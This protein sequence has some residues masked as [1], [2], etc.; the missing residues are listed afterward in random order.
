ML[1]FYPVSF[2]LA[3]SSKL[4][5]NF[6]LFI[7]FF[8]IG[9]IIMRSAG[10]IINDIWDKDIDSKVDRTKTRPIAS[11]EINLTKAII[12]LVILL[13]FGLIILTQFN[14]ESIILGVIILP[15]IFIYPL[16]KKFFFFP[17]SFWD[18]FIIGEY[19]L[20]GLLQNLQSHLT[21]FYS[22]IHLA[23]CGLLPM[24]LS[25]Q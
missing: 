23:L 22:F 6:F 20:D 5:V 21:I 16:A 15:L 25:M 14:T 2:G 13:F 9:A 19:L 18:L 10:C 24:T 11:G 17:N 1:L 8:L 7:C 12:C 4:D 3:I